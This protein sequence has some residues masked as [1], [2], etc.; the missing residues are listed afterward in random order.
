M[1]WPNNLPSHLSNFVGRE[2]E[3]EDLVAVL[4]TARLVTLTGP[5]GA[6]KTRLAIEAACRAR[7]LCPDGAW[8]VY[9][10]SVFEPALV[11]ATVATVLGVRE[12]PGQDLHE[13]LAAF[14]APRSAVLLLDNCEHLLK[15]CAGLAAHLLRSCP[16]L[17]V[18]ATSR[19][20]LAIQGETV[21]RV[22]PMSVPS[23]TAESD[24]DGLLRYD[25]VRLF[26]SRAHQR[27]GD[28]Q[29]TK[30]NARSVAVLTRQL[31]GLPLAIEL[32]AAR[33]SVLT[34]DQIVSR[35]GERFRLLASPDSDVVPRHKTL[36]ATM[37]W[38]YGLL[39]LEEQALF[40]ALSVF[41]GGFTLE[42]AC[43]L[44]APALDEPDVIDLLS[45]LVG[46]SLLSLNPT[47]SPPRY[48]V[49]GTVRRYALERA[50]E[51][52]E[53]MPLRNRHLEW[54]TVLAEH[55]EDELLTESQGY[56]LARLAAEYD[57]MRAALSWALE[58]LP[59]SRDL[60][61]R[62]AGSLGWFWYFRGYVSEGRD[63][64]DRVLDSAGDLDASNRSGKA[65]S[66]G[67]VMAYLQTD[68]ISAR[69]RLESA[70][71]FW[72]A[73]GDP[74]GLGFALTF[75][76]RVLDR[77]GDPRGLEMGERSV[78]LFRRIGDKWPLAL[79]LDFLGE[80]A[81][82]HGAADEAAALHSESL[83]LYREIGNRWGI[84][85]ELSHF[86]QVAIHRRDYKGARRRLE[87]A[88]AIQREVGDKWMLAWTLH[89]LGITLLA[90]G[91]L[92]EALANG[93]ESLL[94]FRQAGD[95]SGIAA[96]LASLSRMA[97]RQDRRDEARSFAEESLT[98]AATLGGSHAADEARHV[99]AELA[100][101]GLEVP[102]EALIDVPRETE[103]LPPRA[104]VHTPVR[105]IVPEFD[106]DPSELTDREVEVLALLAEGL[107]DV[108][109]AERLVLSARTVQAHL[110]SIYSK[111]GVTTRTAAARY[112]L[113]HGLS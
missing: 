106:V 7:D 36:E 48:R 12:E 35:L 96:S 62:L 102:D 10:G 4:S 84:A 41:A 43:A 59:E 91:H 19:E 98:L 16:N 57:N 93:R 49:L 104:Q 21:I 95:R 42:A 15:T 110:R 20:P 18:L 14:L 99:L 54:Y 27:T 60:A 85:L 71:R 79:A 56:A 66:A 75:L 61:L 13:T 58:S 87:E 25:A 23:E 64:L 28:F 82:E 112:A 105:S 6:G 26:V 51:S 33:A 52:G 90:Q 76:A 107:T 92:E 22:P 9:L 78:E 34:V 68:D 89:Y 37:D 3:A 77:Q 97:M 88:A 72:E 17:R 53:L 69:A 103:P 30:D 111:L 45:Q 86:A 73:A 81:R 24:A 100:A 83:S 46:K 108:Q 39:S 70:V 8:W 44:V 65:L 29:L 5:G 63:W 11:A 47:A 80:V 74:R 2:R 67:G 113:T 109:I 31:D 40:R 32:A 1:V 55:S 38:S 94:L 50:R 101:A